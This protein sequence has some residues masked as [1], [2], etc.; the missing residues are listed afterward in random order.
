VFAKAGDRLTVFQVDGNGELLAEASVA[1]PPEARQ[2][3]VEHFVK[4][5]CHAHGHEDG[6]VLTLSWSVPCPE[7]SEEGS[8]DCARTE[9]L[10]FDDAPASEPLRI[11]GG[12]H[13]SVG[14]DVGYASRDT[15]GTGI[16][17]QAYDGSPL[18]KRDLAGELVWEHEWPASP[19][20]ET[21]MPM[22]SS[23]SP[24]DT[25]V[26]GLQLAVEPGLDL[27]YASDVVLLEVDREDAAL[28]FVTLAAGLALEAPYAVPMH[29]PFGRLILL[30]THSLEPI[31][32]DLMVVRHDPA[33]E[34]T[35][36]AWIQR[37]EYLTLVP[38]AGATDS[39]GAIY[40]ATVTGN[41]QGGQRQAL[42]CRVS[43]DFT[44]VRCFGIDGVPHAMVGGGPGE[45]YTL[46]LG[47]LQ[48]YDVPL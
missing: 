10:V 48:R 22:G 7:E 33:R 45:V 2:D 26:T 36:T 16:L 5:L 40:V 46:S 23:L 34:A 3:E 15:E 39:E 6:P 31:P 19:V 14:C 47:G 30:M 43:S 17:L 35:Q 21:Y 18:V 42:L 1:A 24:E 25:L 13:T 12:T 20:H 8:A 38:Y 32:G 37:D 11:A 27:P 28:S 4:M 41:R 44:D 29:D 9:T